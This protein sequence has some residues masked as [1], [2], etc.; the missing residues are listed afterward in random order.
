LFN[1]RYQFVVISRQ[2]STTRDPLDYFDFLLSFFRKTY[3]QISRSIQNTT[4]KK[5]IPCTIG[6]NF[7]KTGYL[8]L[9]WLSFSI[10]LFFAI[11]VLATHSHAADTNPWILVDAKSGELI[12]HHQ[13]TRPWHPA[14]ITKLMTAYTV[15][16]EIKKG[17][18]DL[19]SPVRMSKLASSRPP[20]KM[21]FPIGTIFNVDNALKIIMVKSAN[22]VA[23]ALAESARG[24]HKAFVG[25]MNDNAARLDMTGSHFTNPHGL[26]SIDQVTTA[27]D[28]ALLTLAI[29]NEFPQYAGYFKIPAIRFGKRRMRNHNRLMFSFPG[30]TGMKTGYTCPSGMNVVAR[31]KRGNRELITVVLGGYSGLR[32]NA[33]AAKLLDFGF[34]EQVIY[35]NRPHVRDLKTTMK[36]YAV[37]ANL[38][39][40][41]CKPSWSERKLTKKQRRAKRKLHQAEQNKLRKTYLNSRVKAGPAQRVVL[42]KA[43]GAN[44]F[45]IKLASGGKPPPN[46]GT[47][48]WR[49]DRTSPP[50]EQYQSVLL[51]DTDDDPKI[52]PGRH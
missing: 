12:A 25:A 14:S 40:M 28:M 30:V 44:P 36:Q 47:P 24:S 35:S 15:F 46:I 9:S 7:N 20:S 26:H 45:N 22:D 13:P 19:A 48:V 51:Y 49:P 21:G 50:Y 4:F 17:H 37:P 6:K 32:R 23:V 34:D 41:V 1:N 38:R 3:F 2:Y 31:A 18:I 5:M 39:P 29:Q 52:A 33:L 42:G 10:G 11:G 16:R 8:R 43:T 27:R